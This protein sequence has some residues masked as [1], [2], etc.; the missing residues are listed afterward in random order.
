MGRR[1][2]YRARGRM[3][4][5]SI[6]ADKRRIARGGKDVWWLWVL[7]FVT[8]PVAG[9]GFILMIIAAGIESE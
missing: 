6:A 5:Y 1:N 3:K 2:P 8:I 9:I 7:G 4:G